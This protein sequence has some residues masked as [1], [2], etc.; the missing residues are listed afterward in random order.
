MLQRVRRS[1]F[2]GGAYR[3]VSVA[4]LVTVSVAELMVWLSPVARRASWGGLR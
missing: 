1:R 2:V 3:R 4:P